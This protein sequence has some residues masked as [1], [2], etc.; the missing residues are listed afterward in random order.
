MKCSNRLNI[1]KKHC[2]FWT[3][4]LPNLRGP[5][6]GPRRT[7]CGLRRWGPTAGP[8]WVLLS[9]L[10]G[11]VSGMSLETDLRILCKILRVILNSFY[12]VGGVLSCRVGGGVGGAGTLG[13]TT[14]VTVAMRGTNQST[15]NMNA[16]IQDFPTERCFAMRWWMF[17][18][19]PV[20]GVIVRSR[21]WLLGQRPEQH[22]HCVTNDKTG[23]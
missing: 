3:L 13:N 23:T 19:L 12:S 9:G 21:G 17:F 5:N 10:S 18:A 20:R 4:N 11:H 8:L 15:K 22:T 16:R 6:A 14:A 2:G 1:F 7:S